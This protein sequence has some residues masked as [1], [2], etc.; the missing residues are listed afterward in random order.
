ML[1]EL[2]TDLAVAGFVPALAGHV[3]LQLERHVVRTGADG[4]VVAGASGPFEGLDLAD[5]DAVHEA[6]GGVG[7]IRILRAEAAALAISLARNRPGVEE[8]LFQADAN[9]AIIAGQIIGCQHALHG[10]PKV[11]TNSE[12]MLVL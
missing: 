7:R 5:E 2:D 3:E 1:A 9:E 4:V 12:Q 11:M 10:A 6:T 8:G